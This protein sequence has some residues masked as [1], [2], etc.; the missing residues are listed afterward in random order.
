M[1]A[2]AYSAT[3]CHLVKTFDEMRDWLA[4]EN[5]RYW[6]P[7]GLEILNPISNGLIFVSE[8]FIALIFDVAA[9]LSP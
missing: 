6:L 3:C 7:K 4:Q 9:P 8:L 2:L 1:K 5:R